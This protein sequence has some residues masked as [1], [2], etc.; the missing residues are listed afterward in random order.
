MK[1]SRVTIELDRLISDRFFEQIWKNNPELLK[2]FK[3]MKD[4]NDHLDYENH[5]RQR[6]RKI[7]KL[8]NEINL[9]KR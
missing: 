5:M 3:E 7:K 6:T 8:K 9:E 1:K 4:Y 2:S